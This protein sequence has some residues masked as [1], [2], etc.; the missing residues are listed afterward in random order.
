[1]DVDDEAW[2]EQPNSHAQRECRSAGSLEE[3]NS[4][5]RCCDI[6]IIKMRK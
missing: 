4:A 5:E 1:M 6:R 3:D 2:P